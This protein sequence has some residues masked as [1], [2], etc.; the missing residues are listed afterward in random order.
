MKKHTK[1]CNC[2]SQ[3]GREAGGLDR[4]GVPAGGAGRASKATRSI[5]PWYG[6][7]VP[8]G[9]LCLIWEVTEKVLKEAESY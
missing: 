4:E 2:S 9:H 8:V 1:S 3:P 6:P 7:R 5:R